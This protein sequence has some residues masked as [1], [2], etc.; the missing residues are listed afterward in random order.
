MS[1]KGKVPRSTHPPPRNNICP[2]VIFYSFCVLFFSANFFAYVDTQFLYPGLALFPSELLSSETARNA[3]CHPKLGL[4]TSVSGVLQGRVPVEN[5]TLE[6]FVRANFDE[7][8]P[9]GLGN[10]TTRAL[11]RLRREEAATVCNGTGALSIAVHVPFQSGGAYK[12]AIKK[13]IIAFAAKYAG[14]D[15]TVAVRLVTEGFDSL[16]TLTPAKTYYPI[17][18]HE[19][20]VVD[21]VP[22]SR[23]LEQE[24]LVLKLMVDA[25]V[26]VG[27][28]KTEMSRA[29]HQARGVKICADVDTWPSL[30]WGL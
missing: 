16:D 23:T 28:S 26:F 8:P 6:A 30:L 11:A 21:V 13:L 22:F 18:L 27:S 17:S 4:A 29:V 10:L 25:D 5:S 2:Y 19:T 7:Y 20:L 3:P 1:A 15:Q 24:L 14:P 9:C 12:Y